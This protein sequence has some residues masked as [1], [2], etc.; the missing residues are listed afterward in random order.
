[1][2]RGVR[3][4]LEVETI[5]YKKTYGILLIYAAALLLLGLLSGDIR[6]LLPGLWTIIINEDTLITDYIQLAGLGP[7]FVNAAIVTY[8]S[9]AILYF[10]K[11]PPNG[12]TIV[13]IGLMS[14]FAL[15]G[16]NF[17]NIWPI[18]LGT[19][20]YARLKREPFSKYAGVALLSTALAPVVSFVGLGG[21]WASLP[22]AVLVGVSIG[23]ILP[24]LSGYTFRIQ[25]G[26]NLY[27]MGF[28]CGLVAM[29]LVPVMNSL[30][31]VPE[32][33]HFWAT[34]Y[35]LFFT[36]ILTL[37]CVVLIAAGLLFGNRPVWAAWAGYRRLLQTSGRAP[38]D[39]LR[40]FG[41]A[42]VLINTGVNGLIATAYI[43]LTGGDL[44]GPTLGGILT[45]MG[46]SAFG[47][48]ARNILPIM[49]GVL[50]GGLVMG[51]QVNTPSLQLAGLFCTTLAP[52][53]GY[54]GWPVGLLAGFLHASVVLHAGIPVAG[55]NLYNNGFSGGLIAIVLF[56]VITAV[57]RRRRP[58]L[59]DEDYFEV[60]EHDEP[61]T[62]PPPA[63]EKHSAES[64]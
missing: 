44:N 42:P 22:A 13:D 28:A 7:A 17:V 53:S 41:A 46:F 60:F 59:Q 12:Y 2:Q 58:V 54:F 18:I 11:D 3:R 36:C 39:Y 33:V 20:L 37:L 52:I 55:M 35:N 43:L 5:R 14:G 49:A 56:P 38:E 6:E 57:F 4:A 23:F 19:W 9:I 29:L 25:N 15:F 50:L 21:H 34:G 1:M 47:K 30:G 62:P 32:K 31:K 64:N 45:I 8:I 10:A 16:K 48:H 51:G 63:E 61:V 40:M 27:N 26:M 24:P